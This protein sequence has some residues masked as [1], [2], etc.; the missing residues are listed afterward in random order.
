VVDAVGEAV[1]QH[2]EGHVL[3]YEPVEGGIVAMPPAI[4]VDD[5]VAVGIAEHTP[6]EAV[7]L[8]AF[9]LE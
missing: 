2:Y 4:V 1:A 3:F 9:P 7:V 8:Y 5:L 6:A